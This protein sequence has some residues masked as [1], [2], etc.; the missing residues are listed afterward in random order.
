MT[1]EVL[2]GIYETGFSRVHHNNNHSPHHLKDTS[3]PPLFIT[4]EDD[5]SS[6]SSSSFVADTKRYR[7]KP[8]K[9][10]PVKREDT[11]MF[12]LVDNNNNNNNNNN[13][14]DQKTTTITAYQTEVIDIEEECF[15][16]KKAKEIQFKQ[17]VLASAE[18]HP[19]VKRKKKASLE[20]LLS[21]V[22]A[23]KQKIEQVRVIR[24]NNS[25]SEQKPA[26]PE[27]RQ[28][29]G[30]K[31]NHTNTNNGSVNA[32]TIKRQGDVTIEKNNISIE[33]VNRENSR[34]IENDYPDGTSRYEQYNKHF[35]PRSPQRHN[36]HITTAMRPRSKSPLLQHHKIDKE[37]EYH[38]YHQRHRRSHHRPSRLRSY[39]EQHQRHHRRHASKSPVYD[40]DEDNDMYRKQTRTTNH[41]SQFVRY[42]SS[43]PSLST[44]S[45]STKTMNRERSI[46]PSYELTGNNDNNVIVDDEEDRERRYEEHLIQRKEHDQH[47]PQHQTSVIRPTARRA[48]PRATRYFYPPPTSTTYFT[49]RLRSNNNNNNNKKRQ[50]TSSSTSSQ[51]SPSSSFTGTCART[52]P[53]LST[54]LPDKEVNIP[55]PEYMNYSKEKSFQQQQQA[56][57]KRQLN[58]NE[59][60][61]KLSNSQLQRRLVANA[62]ERSRVHALSNAFEAL[63]G[64]IP[65]YSTDQK[66]SKLTILR[67]AINYI[68]ALTQLLAPK[69]SDSERRFNE[70]VEECTSVLQTEYGRSRK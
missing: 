62:R 40:N 25:D 28:Q 5:T 26:S 32:G 1:Q 70:C 47:Q 31:E 59:R 69:T 34:K 13:I 11:A 21:R 23:K 46:S 65:S 6:S 37:V 20:Q 7:R 52:N 55:P 51:L 38:H 35:S 39:E 27:S 14:N 43:S 22:V 10:I 44:S 67:V 12:N 53:S 54:A 58:T 42:S 18:Q 29:D 16:A 9:S 57:N 49:A 50:S 30:A 66:L 4:G 36:N 56:S 19:V 68:D 3:S 17:P 2:N 15:K 24:E 63:R 48:S 8:M 64:T 60:Y 61:S 41:K 45:L 33:N